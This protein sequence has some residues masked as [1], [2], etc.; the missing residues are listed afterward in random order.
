MTEQEQVPRPKELI[1]DAE[2]LTTEQIPQPC[3]VRDPD[4]GG[5]HRRT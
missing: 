2:D 1:R 4:A 3:V 5:Q